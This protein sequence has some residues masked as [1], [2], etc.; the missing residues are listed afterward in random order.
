MM[1]WTYIGS[2]WDGYSNDGNGK[3]QVLLKMVL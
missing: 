2:N 3:C 1:G